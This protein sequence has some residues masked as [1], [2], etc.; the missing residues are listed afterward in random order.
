MADPP[1]VGPDDRR[2]LRAHVAAAASAAARPGQ[3]SGAVDDDLE[4]VVEQRRLGQPLPVPGQ[5]PFVPPVGLPYVHL[6][7]AGALHEPSPECTTSRL[8]RC[9]AVQTL[10]DAARLVDG[11]T[12]AQTLLI[13]SESGLSDC[14][15]WRTSDA[16]DEVADALGETSL[17]AWPPQLQFAADAPGRRATPRTSQPKPGHHRTV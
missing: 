16:R 5:L 1:F 6:H 8:F 10:E 11:Q 7:A 13:V 14:V 2:I 4:H 17:A 9:G 3:V 15:D 12:Q